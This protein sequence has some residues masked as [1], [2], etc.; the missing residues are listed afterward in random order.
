LNQLILI[1]HHNTNRSNVMRSKKGPA[2]LSFVFS[3]IFCSAISASGIHPAPG[4]PLSGEILPFFPNGAYDSKIPTPEKVIG[5]VMGAKPCRYEQ[6]VDYLVALDKSSAEVILREYGETYEGRKLYYLIISS[7]E[8]VAR[9]D[10]IQQEIG[11]LADPRK[12]TSERQAKEL[13]EKLPVVA[14][15]AYSIHGDELSS[16]DAALQLAYQLAA[17]T[18]TLTNKLKENLIIVID[19]LQNPDGRE[20]IL[21]QIQSFSGKIVNWDAQTLEHGGVWP[22]G[23]GNH[24]L[25]DLNRDWFALV[26]P[27]S[28]GKIKAILDW[29]PQVLVDCHEMGAFDTYLFS[30]PREPF[31]P[32]WTSAIRKWW[33]AFSQDQARAF[34]QYGWSYYTR[35]WNEEWFPGYGSSWSIFLGAVGIL[36]E[37]A[38][39]SG[40]QVKKPDKTILTYRETVHHQFSSSLANLTT[41]ANN[42]R[43]LLNDFYQEKRGAVYPKQATT[44][45]FVPGENESRTTQFIQTMLKQNIEVK[46]GQKDFTATDLTDIWRDKYS[47]KTFPKGSYIISSAQPLSHLVKAILEFD[48]KVPSDFLKTERLELEKG[49]G[50]RLYEITAWSLPLAYN[51]AAYRTEKS[52]SVETIP[53]TETQTAPG[54]LHNPKASYGYVFSWGTFNSAL[55]IARL[56]EKD[57]K[58]RVAEKPFRV[59]GRNFEPGAILLRKSENLANVAEVLGEIAQ[60]SGIEIWGVTTA[61][62]ED[63]ADL[64]GGEFELLQQPKI[65]LLTNSPIDF[66]NF[67]AIWHLLDQKLG[68]RITN[69]DIAQFGGLDLSLYNVLVF[70]SSWGGGGEYSRQLGKGGIAKLKSWIE[71]GGT[72]IAMGSASAFASDTTNGLSQI[73]LKEQ[74]L[75]S[76]ENFESAIEQ[77]EKA[78]GFQI[79]SLDLWESGKEEVEQKVAAEKATGKPDQQ[80]VKEANKRGVLFMPRGAILRVELDKEHW[81]GFGAGDK[82]PVLAYTSEAFLSKEPA[83]TVGRFADGAKLRLAGLLWPEARS[84]WAK[85]SYLTREARGKGQI[86]L[87]AT[88]P[89]FRGYFAG[90]EQLLINAFIFGPGMGAEIPREW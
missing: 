13:I 49:K 44:Y 43:E 18:D 81:L 4:L 73:R 41:A 23:R 22:W 38:G 78:K 47:K 72:L 76:L 16:T 28:Q 15:M 60:E 40:S 69:L 71:S 35:E 19:P 7:N 5:F 88:P 27:E 42:R 57:F 90:A 85:T 64:G 61:L 67:G 34:D 2:F 83:L 55:A 12:I 89:N 80:M 9:L 77:L 87:F 39:V 3:I 36:Y 29:N 17:G 33:R 54:M 68:L 20:R 37:Q 6:M 86:I 84:R 66:T 63:G 30:P 79:D 62:A 21:S 32:F 75:D 11:L 8:N 48:L 56:L 58:L 70:P 46:Q 52:V 53:V 65:G 14:W 59:E 26:H 74:V 51:L 45:I 50:T 82:V 31:N 25:F 1:E 24:Y 10:R